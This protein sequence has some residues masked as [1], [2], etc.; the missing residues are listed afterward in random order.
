MIFQKKTLL[1]FNI[2]KDI[3]VLERR[4][5]KLTAQIDHGLLYRMFCLFNQQIRLPHG[6]PLLVKPALILREAVGLMKING[7]RFCSRTRLLIMSML[8]AILFC[9]TGNINMVA[10]A[11]WQRTVLST[12]GYEPLVL[13]DVE[14]ILNKLLAS[15]P[16][17]LVDSS[18]RYIY[19]VRAYYN[20]PLSEKQASRLQIEINKYEQRKDAKMMACPKKNAVILFFSDPERLSY[21]SASAETKA[22]FIF[23]HVDVLISFEGLQKK[24]VI[25]IGE[26]DNFSDR[27]FQ[28]EGHAV[29]RISLR[30]WEQCEDKE[31]YVKTVLQKAVAACWRSEEDEKRSCRLTCRA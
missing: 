30:A 27:I 6:Q 19:Q 21:Q 8:N 16:D 26:S 12:L 3:V 14:K 22:F 25:Q 5:P 28:Q 29:C 18:A 11:L 24:L 9:P 7:A 2:F 23:K 13:E 20:I 1:C 4:N 17:Q 10:K 15:A 31:S